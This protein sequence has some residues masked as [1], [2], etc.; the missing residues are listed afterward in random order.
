MVSQITRIEARNYKSLEQVDVAL[1]PFTV[2][3]GPNGSGKTNLLSVLRFVRDAARFGIEDALRTRGGFDR[4]KRQDGK[5]GRVTLTLHGNVTSHASTGAP[6]RYQLSLGT[7][8]GEVTRR[9]EFT[10]KRMA[11]QGRR[12]TLSANET[13]VARIAADGSDQS[14]RTRRLAS[15]TTT[16]LGTF[17]QLNDDEVGRGPSDFLDFL[18]DIRYLDPAVREARVPSRLQR[19]SID[20]SASNLSAAL[21]E[22]SRVDPDGLE[23]LTRDLR[24]CLPGLEAIEFR[25]GGGSAETVVVS[26]V[27]AGLTRPIDLADASFGTVRLLALLTALHEPNP[28]ALTVIEEVDHGL[29][30]Y[31]LD[32][33]VGRMREASKRTQLLVASHSPTLVNRLEA[34]EIV[35]CDRD[36]ESGESIIPS[37]SAAE[38]AAAVEESG[39]LPGELWF[40]GSLGGVPN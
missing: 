9:E 16:M 1:G 5:Q 18:T 39:Y 11:G 38:I 22:L 21:Y 31:A 25:Q 6:D 30:P 4:I 10:Y 34:S 40:S 33:L 29:H 14:A 19:G 13:A 15:S 35:V 23:A 20:D 28:P 2:L 37:R 3:V 26:L 12:I 17:A 8:K 36:A 7:S 32:V 24:D 27:E